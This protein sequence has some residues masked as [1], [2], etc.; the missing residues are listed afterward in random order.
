[1]VLGKEGGRGVRADQRLEA[2]EPPALRRWALEVPGSPFERV[3]RA[4]AVEARLAPAGDG[5]RADA[6]AAPVAARLGPVRRLHA[7][8]RR[9]PPA[10]RGARRDGARRGAEGLTP[11]M[12]RREQKTWGWGEPG[13]GPG[14]AGSRAPR[15]CASGSACRARSS[16]APVGADRVRL[17]RSAAPPALRAAL[18][19]VVGAEHVRDDDARALAARGR[20]VLPRPA[21]DARRRRGRRARPR[22]RARATHDEVQAVLHACAEGGAAVIPFG[23]GTSVVGGVAPDRGRWDAAVSLDLGRLDAVLDVDVRSR[24][25]RV[26]AG[27]AAAGARPRARRAR[28]AAR[29]CAAELRVGDRRRLRRDALGRAGVDRLRALRRARRG[30]CAARRPRASSRRS[31]RRRAPP[32][33]TCARSC[34]ARRARSA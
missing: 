13:A 15:C 24:T 25:A 5:A 26:Q 33:R 28:A 21:G 8:P 1:M 3:L 17:P 19:R 20:Q 23:G 9:P 10:R 30:A 6:G 4:S 16:S 34:S 7:A 32:A 29:P 12:L 11:F 22:R 18:E 2:S 31:A 14:A 27:T